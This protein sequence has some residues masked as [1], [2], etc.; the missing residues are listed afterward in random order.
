M[1]HQLKEKPNQNVKT[2]LSEISLS[3]QKVNLLSSNQTGDYFTRYL[4]GLQLSRL[5]MGR[6]RRKTCTEISFRRMCKTKKDETEVNWYVR[7]SGESFQMFNMLVE[8]LVYNLYK[9]EVSFGENPRLGSVS[10]FIPQPH[11]FFGAVCFIVFL[12]SHCKFDP[13][14]LKV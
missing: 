8:S 11:H 13:A 6:G 4:M 12:P 7:G 2:T 3:Y 9:F 10:P 5:Q 14:G 1:N